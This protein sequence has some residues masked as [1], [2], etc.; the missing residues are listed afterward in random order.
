MTDGNSKRYIGRTLD[1][2]LEVTEQSV[3]ILLKD[4]GADSFVVAQTRDVTYTLAIVDAAAGTVAVQ[5]DGT[6][7]SEPAVCGLNGSTFGGSMIKVGWIGTDMKIEFNLGNGRVLTT[8]WVVSFE[9]VR[10][11]EKTRKFVK[12]A[13]DGRF[14]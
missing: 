5:S 9:T 13:C 14:C 1:R 4:I 11:A 3:G 7:F 8:D 10:D 6:S 2:E 12:R